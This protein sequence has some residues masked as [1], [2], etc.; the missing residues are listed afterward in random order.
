MLT[1]PG[2]CLQS[3]LAVDKTLAK[4][5][6]LDLPDED[7][8]EAANVGRYNAAVMYSCLQVL[9][10]IVDV[11]VLAYLSVTVVKSIIIFLVVLSPFL[12]V[13]FVE[14][15]RENLPAL[16]WLALANIAVGEKPLCE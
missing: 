15:F 8:L 3:F 11:L 7:I 14:H 10:C 12:C 16:V 2:N 9:L 4:A 5:P 6:N 1:V 13:A